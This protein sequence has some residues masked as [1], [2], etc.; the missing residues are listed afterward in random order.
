MTLSPAA[1]EALC[2]HTWP[3]NV[4]EL[5]N[6]LERAVLLVEGDTIQPGHLQLAAA[7]PATAP[8]AR[9]RWT[10][11]SRSTGTAGCP[12]SPRRAL[13]EVERRKIRRVLDQAGGDRSRA[14]ELLQVPLRFLQSKMR[15][16]RME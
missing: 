5:Q 13:A 7:L 10:R 11:G 9:G 6:C 3:G 14:A 8:G 16:L 12:T 15:E 2:A 4:R 1:L